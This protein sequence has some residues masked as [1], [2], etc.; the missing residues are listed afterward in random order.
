MEREL[1]H[2]PP[3]NSP[4]R[5]PRAVRA[6]AVAF[7]ALVLVAAPP[8]GATI[9]AGAPV[10]TA[11]G[12]EASAQRPQTRSR[13]KA[14]ASAKRTAA[15]RSNVKRT[16]KR[17]APRR[18]AAPAGPA[19]TSPNGQAALA[20]DLQGMIDRRV[21]G[22]K[23]GVMVVSLSRGD[24]LFARNA[25]DMMQPASTMKLFATAVALDRFGPDHTFSTDVL[26][27]GAVSAD[28]TVAGNIYLRADGDPAMSARFFRDPNLPMATLARNVAAA[29]VRRVSGDLLYDATA[30]DD[31]RIP[32]GWK[33]TYLGAAYA[34]RVSALSLNEN[35]V[36]VVVHPDGRVNLEPATS[37]I[38][39]RNRVRVTKGGGGRIAA[40]RASDGAIDVSG[41]IGSRSGPLRYSLVVD[42]PALFT[43]GALRAALQ[44]AG[45]TVAGTVRPA[46]TPANAQKVASF[47][48]PPLAQIVS[49]MNRES[50]NIVAELLYRNAARAGAPNGMSSGRV[51]EAH[52]REFL[53]KKVGAD[54]QAIR[55]SDGSGLS[56]LDY[57]TPRMM[58]Q[59]LS[60]AHK[61]PWSSAFHGSLPVAGES[62]LLRRRMRSTPAQGNLH[63][64]T[65]TTNTVIGLGG[66]VTARDG[67]I[68]AFA[69]LYNGA[70][71]WNA[72]SAM[73]AM[74]AT[75][76]NFVR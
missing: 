43:A 40:R 14:R 6:S 49:L 34:A 19:W 18:A 7:F 20:A 69:F 22:G 76:A 17:S 55:A 27:D 57:M 37:T 46:R 25:G 47:D 2:P 12:A 61:G 59:L 48:S 63:A 67:E 51:A 54:P 4:N 33:T 58:V 45:V 21:R 8:Q 75:I 28:G 56:T 10:W 3:M 74:G 41:S 31:Q 23:F 11:G 24:T 9:V 62:E 71:R 50:I 52:M 26:R 1:P 5:W 64:K 68:V 39:L 44:E 36:W 60:Y 70:D 53:Q 16:A 38:P 30:F 29:G 65:G 73:D 32:D 66:F 72:K 35:L 15:R 42:D 13:A